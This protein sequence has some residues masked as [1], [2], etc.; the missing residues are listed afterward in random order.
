MDYPRP[1]DSTPN[2]GG[3]SFSD[4]RIGS[5]VGPRLAVSLGVVA[6]L[7]ASIAGC[8]PGPRFVGEIR[9]TSSSQL[10]IARAVAHR[11]ASGIVID[12]DVR[13]PNGY[14]GYV[15][16]YLK[17]EG[18]DG[19]GTV[20]ATTKASWGEFISRRFRLAYFRATLSTSEPASIKTITVNVVTDPIR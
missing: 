7:A 3:N 13:R 11:T 2:H 19:A 14:A 15:P 9:T 17:I 16:G 8:A 20:I 5:I 4:S 10:E 12:G 18:Y 1:S 6:L